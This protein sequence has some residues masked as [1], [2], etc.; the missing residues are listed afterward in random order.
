MV[1]T[2]CCLCLPSYCSLADDLSKYGVLLYPAPRQVSDFSAQACQHSSWPW[3]SVPLLGICQGCIGRVRLGSTCA[4]HPAQAHDNMLFSVQATC[5]ACLLP[6]MHPWMMMLCQRRRMAF[7]RYAA[8]LQT[9]TVWT[10][11][12]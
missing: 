7:M 1:Y 11:V 12:N 10:Q 9:L 8:L 6:P 5:A 3:L 2:M 4:Q